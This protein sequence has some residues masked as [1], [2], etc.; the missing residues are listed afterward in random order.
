MT[1]DG[2]RVVTDEAV[3]LGR[4]ARGIGFL[5]EEAAESGRIRPLVGRN[6]NWLGAAEAADQPRSS[7]SWRRARTTGHSLARM[8]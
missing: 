8:K 2:V 3:L 4:M 6:A 5:T 7:R 1:A